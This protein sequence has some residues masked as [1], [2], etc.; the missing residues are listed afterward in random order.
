VGETGAGVGETGAGVGATGA[1]VGAVGVTGVA[2]G[3]LVGA[4][5]GWA[6]GSVV[7][8]PMLRSGAITTSKDELKI[9]IK[10][11]ASSGSSSTRRTPLKSPGKKESGSL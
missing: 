9:S 4:G 11:L 8:L 1:G 7:G 5:V 6:D 3:V 2:V 10:L